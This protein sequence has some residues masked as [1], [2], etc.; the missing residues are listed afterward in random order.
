MLADVRSDGIA[1]FRGV[2]TAGPEFV[3]GPGEP[4]IEKLFDAGL[5][6]VEKRSDVLLLG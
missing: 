3:K 2:L 5:F 1:S 4:A 6:A